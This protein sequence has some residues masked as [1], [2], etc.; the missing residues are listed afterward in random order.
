MFNVVNN[1]YTTLMVCSPSL[2]SKVDGGYN[3][4]PEFS[5]LFGDK[6]IVTRNENIIT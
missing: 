4:V 6:K 2:N 5:E 1:N 3:Y